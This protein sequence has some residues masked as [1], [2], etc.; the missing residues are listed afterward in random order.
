MYNYLKPRTRSLQSGTQTYT[1]PLLLAGAMEQLERLAARH[2]SDTRKFRRAGPG[3]VVD[4]LDLKDLTRASF[5]LVMPK[6]AVPKN[7][8]ISV[9]SPLG[10]SLLGLKK[11]DISCV[12]LWGCRHEFQIL[13]IHHTDQFTAKKEETPS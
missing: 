6:D 4:L 3:C 12:K 1:T 10:A 8:R 2:N 7:H 11:G 5:E 13:A 9:L